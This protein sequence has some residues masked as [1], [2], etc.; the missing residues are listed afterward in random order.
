M[1]FQITKSDFDVTQDEII[2][3]DKYH[4]PIHT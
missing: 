1:E 3:Y 2:T 4:E